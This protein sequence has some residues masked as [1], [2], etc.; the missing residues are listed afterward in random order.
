MH[1]LTTGFKQG[2]SGSGAKK[3]TAHQSHRLISCTCLLQALNPF[4][5][6]I[7]V[8]Y[9][10][11]YNDLRR[12]SYFTCM[13]SPL[14][15]HNVVSYNVI[16]Y[17]S[18]LYGTWYT[19]ALSCYYNALCWTPLDSKR[20]LVRTTFYLSIY[21]TQ[22]WDSPYLSFKLFSNYVNSRCAQYDKWAELLE[23]GTRKHGRPL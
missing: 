14:P 5:R 8:F 1:L 7:T 21:L 9:L 6:S 23:G 19:G 3:L 11:N 2:T 13:L 15:A 4:K 22:F 20:T 18:K 10:R 17:V 16:G 12:Y